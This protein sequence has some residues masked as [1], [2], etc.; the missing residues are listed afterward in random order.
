MEKHLSSCKREVLG[1]CTI[2]SQLS[3]SSLSRSW[4]N[5][6]V[7]S[8]TLC[9]HCAGGSVCTQELQP[10]LRRSR[11]ESKALLTA[12]WQHRSMSRLQQHLSLWLQC[13]KHTLGCTL[14]NTPSWRGAQKYLRDCAKARLCLAKPELN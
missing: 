10:A 13:C 9:W 5:C 6:A 4:I 1:G 7:E 14:A 2:N 3:T 8:L 12:V 11:T